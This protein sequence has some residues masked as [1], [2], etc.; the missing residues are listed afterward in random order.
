MVKIKPLLLWIGLFILGE[1]LVGIRNDLT[2]TGHLSPLWSIV[3]TTLVISIYLIPATFISW[4]VIRFVF[5]LLKK[6]NPLEGNHA[7]RNVFILWLLLFIPIF[8]KPLSSSAYK[9]YTNEGA[10]FSLKYPSSMTLYTSVD[11][12]RDTDK[13][14][15]EITTSKLTNEQIDM[16]GFT[17]AKEKV[18]LKKAAS[19]SQFDPQIVFKQDMGS[20]KV[21]GQIVSRGNN[22]I[23]GSLQTYLKA[24]QT[25]IIS[26][27]RS[28][29]FYNKG[30]EVKIT[31]VGNGKDFHDSSPEFF[32]PNE[33]DL[34][35]PKGEY[36]VWVDDK[37]DDFS[38][39]YD[40]TPKMKEFYD[41]LVS[42][43]GPDAAQR[44]YSDF[45]QIVDSIEFK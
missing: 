39:A 22:I 23:Y 44:W 8:L 14:Y 19:G 32:K 45:D 3:V 7:K 13:S 26:F 10:G 37:E 25:H 28:F 12:P 30:Y 2:I 40:A 6:Q 38:G 29:T 24:P 4:L 15:I 5:K 16:G 36:Y 31:S 20:G 18:E 41:L 33:S 34:A 42:G 11:H 35:Y 9:T 1:I 21:Q 27:E 17:S 43:K